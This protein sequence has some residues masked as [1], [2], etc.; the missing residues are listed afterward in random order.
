MGSEAMK[1]PQIKSRDLEKKIQDMKMKKI[2]KLT[3]AYV[4]DYTVFNYRID[5]V[6]NEA[7]GF[8]KNHQR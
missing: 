2:E 4:Q 5:K 8:I 6:L 1:L 7:Y 3:K